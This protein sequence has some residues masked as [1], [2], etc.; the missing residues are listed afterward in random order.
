LITFIEFAKNTLLDKNFYFIFFSDFRG[1][2]YSLSRF[3]PVSNKIIRHIIKY[4]DT[5]PDFYSNIY[6]SP[7]FKIL[8]DNFFKE[9]HQFNLKNKSNFFYQALF[10]ILFSIA[11]LFKSKLINDGRVLLVDMLNYGINIFKNKGADYS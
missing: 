7:I 11:S 4:K 2:I 10:F 1:R 8:Q 9:L 3:G 5:V 6:D